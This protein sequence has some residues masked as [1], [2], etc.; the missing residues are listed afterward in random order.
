MNRRSAMTGTA[1][2]AL[3]TASL[4][5][6]AGVPGAAPVVRV[7]LGWYPPEKVNEVAAI[8]DYEGKPLGEAIKKLPGLISYY[9]GIDREQHALT[10]VSLWKDLASAEQMATLQAMIEQ[11]KALAAI[12]VK[13]IRPITNSESL[14]TAGV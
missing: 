6:T 3:G 2:L 5:G 11:G 10:N 12:G 9:S 7:S 1:F 13:F 14:W 8:L 4:E